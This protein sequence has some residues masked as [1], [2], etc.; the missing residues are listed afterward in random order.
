MIDRE[1]CYKFSYGQLL[2][3]SL[4]ALCVSNIEQQ[5]TRG[6]EWIVHDINTRTGTV[7]V[8]KVLPLPADAPSTFKTQPGDITFIEEL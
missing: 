6:T 1:D 4:R 5:M 2:D 7:V 3:D 8:S